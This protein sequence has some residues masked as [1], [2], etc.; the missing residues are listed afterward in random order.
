MNKLVKGSIAAAAG[1]TLLM[2]GAGSLAIWNDS[3]DTSAGSIATGELNITSTGP[4]AWADGITLWVPGDTDTYT[5]T[6]DIEAAG[7][8][9]AFVVDADFAEFDANGIETVTTVTVDGVEYD[10]SV[11]L[12][13]GSYEA[14]VSVEVTFDADNTDFQNLT[15]QD[16]GDISITV[17]QVP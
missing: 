16:L 11:E 7:D 13:A 9:I 15:A 8:N 14:V 6:F 12:P 10:N 4:G 17:T 5:E 2:G 3:A 1:I